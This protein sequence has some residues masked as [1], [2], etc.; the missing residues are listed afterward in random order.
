MPVNEKYSPAPL[1]PELGPAFYDA[2][3]PAHFPQAILRF[4]NQE[5][6][7]RVGLGSL[8][9]AE[10]KDC[11]W[12]FYPLPLNLPEPL[13]LRYHGH[14]FSHYNPD[15]GDGRGFV[16]A[17]LRDPVSGKNLD[18]ATKGSGQTPWSRRGDGRLTLKGAMREALATGMLEALGVNT[19]KT[20]SIFETGEELDRGDEP[21]PTRSAVLTRLSHSHVRIGTFQRLA[22]LGEKDNLQK[23][24][25]FSL[26][27][28]YPA[29]EWTPATAAVTLF[30]QTARETAK[31]TARWM[32]AGFV[33]GVLNTDNINITGESFDYGPYRFLPHYDTGFVAA[34]FDHTGLY[35]YG[36]QPYVMMWN[37]EQFASSLQPLEPDRAELERGFQI[38]QETFTSETFAF[39][40]Q[41]LGLTCHDEARIENLF[42]KSIHFLD[43]SKMPFEAFF[44]DWFGGLANETRALRS[45]RANFYAGAA[46]DEFYK[47]LEGFL[48]Q[49]PSLLHDPYLD[50]AQPVSLVIDEIE[51]LW[52]PI[53]KHDDW[54]PFQEKIADFARLKKFLGN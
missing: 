39:F 31:T 1:W 43:Q 19:S 30:H 38:F 48:P 46:F 45:A 26:K 2:V 3:K 23:L 28:Y 33:H 24:C 21:S 12:S 7:E 35:A 18:L 40:L 4:R 14:Q 6:A 53:D 32:L 8:S 17:Q 15:L 10:W 42:I 5:W 22:Y 36:R 27:H 34:Y 54:K 41:R 50:R 29:V 25:A 51:S 47:A 9:A 49:N 16:Y 11:F 37:L 20:L 52:S 13:A 44:F